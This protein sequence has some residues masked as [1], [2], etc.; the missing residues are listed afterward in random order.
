MRHRPLARSWAD[1]VCDWCIGGVRNV[2]AGS[3]GGIGDNTNDLRQSGTL[4]SGPLFQIFSG[5][6]D[7]RPISSWNYDLS[8]EWYFDRVGSLTASAFL[9]DING[10]PNNGAELRSYTSPGGTTIEVEFNGPINSAGGTLKGVELSYQQTHQLIHGS[11][12]Q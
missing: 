9:K 3:G 7:V 5:N 11:G 8:V 12:P 1:L 6:R 4:E 2:G 10:I